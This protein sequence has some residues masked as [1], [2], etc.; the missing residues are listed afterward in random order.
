VDKVKKKKIVSCNFSHF[1]FSVLSKLGDAD[2]GM[3]QGDQC[4]LVW[5]VLALHIWIWHPHV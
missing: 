1:L 5:Y 3:V 2:F 4:G